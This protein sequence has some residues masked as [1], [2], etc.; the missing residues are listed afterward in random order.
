MEKPCTRV[1]H[2]TPPAHWACWLS[3]LLD[4]SHFGDFTF[5]C[6][7]LLTNIFVIVKF[8]KSK[9]IKAVKKSFW[10]KKN[11]TISYLFSIPIN[12]SDLKFY[13][14]FEMLHLKKLE[15]IFLQVGIFFFYLEKRIS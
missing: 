7:T 4:L 2:A 12:C 1:R 10:K 15:K 8:S 9:K 14:S 5:D 13:C 6:S 3:C 11:L